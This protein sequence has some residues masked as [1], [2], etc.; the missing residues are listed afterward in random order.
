LAC[1]PGCLGRWTGLAGL[2]TADQEGRTTN[3]GPGRGA[4]RRG[5]GRMLTNASFRGGESS[6]GPDWAPVEQ[7]D[8]GGGIGADGS[9]AAERPGPAWTA[10]VHIG[11]VGGSV[12]PPGRSAG[13][14]G[15]FRLRSGGS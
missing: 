13:D 14:E 6:H 1:T 3:N 4:G 9:E 15:G 11:T 2:G 10:G 5:L 7:G 8:G 12:V